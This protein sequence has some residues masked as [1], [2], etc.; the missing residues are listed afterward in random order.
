MM[1]KSRQEVLKLITDQDIKMLPG[2][3]NNTKSLL[4]GLLK[5]NPDERLTVE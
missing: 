2:F 3:S 4:H 5:R 1:K